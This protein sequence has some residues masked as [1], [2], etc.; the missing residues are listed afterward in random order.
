MA[1]S[2]FSKS[3]RKKLSKLHQRFLAARYRREVAAATKRVHG[4]FKPAGQNDLVVVALM[5]DAENHVTSFVRHHLELGARQVVLMD[6]GSV[7][8]SVQCALQFS[9]V[10]LLKCDLPFG[11]HKLAMKRYLSDRFGKGCWCLIADIDE[12]FD[13]PYSEALTLRG[14][15]DYLNRHCFSAVVA[16]MLDLFSDGPHHKW[17][18]IA[19]GLEEE[20]RFFDVS[21]ID[22]RPYRAH[23]T[24][25]VAD[26]EFRM[27]SGGIRKSAFEM[28]VSPNLTKHPLLFPNRGATPC[29]KSSHRCRHARIADVTCVLEHYKFDRQFYERCRL[30]VD[31]KNYYQ[32]SAQYREYLSA[33]QH[34]PHLTLKRE[35]A[36]PYVSISA[37]ADAGLLWVSPA[38]RKYCQQGR[39]AA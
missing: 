32:E 22:Q 36:Q 7:D 31:R 15:L 9:E 37:L 21:V 11:T 2:Q 14:F 12:R 35:T 17:P 27:W 8:A 25:V 4:E 28:S 33:L 5:R 6:N 19:D 1:R 24:N 26:N 39:R 16:Q 38:Y 23:P 29:F 13:Y 18:D 10:T 34:D 30:A 20:H 3:W